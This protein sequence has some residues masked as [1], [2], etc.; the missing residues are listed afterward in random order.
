MALQ[1]TDLSQHCVHIEL[2]NHPQRVG[3][4]SGTSGYFYMAID[5][6]HQKENPMQVIPGELAS[7]AK[8]IGNLGTML[9]EANPFAGLPTSSI[10]PAAADEVSAA[11]ASLFNNHS[12][13]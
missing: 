1:H 6:R 8:D 9:E 5:K 2:A 13:I 7:A 3:T 4:F 11:I 10:L 12:T